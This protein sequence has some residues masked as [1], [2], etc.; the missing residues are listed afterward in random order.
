METYLFLI[1]KVIMR[2]QSRLQDALRLCEEAMSLY[3]NFAKL[4]GVKGNILLKMNRIEEA[5]SVLEI[6]VQTPQV[7]PECYYNLGLA[8]VQVSIPK[9]CQE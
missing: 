5:I 8:Y 9:Q 4:Y 1:E 2:D 7:V 6:G 3:P